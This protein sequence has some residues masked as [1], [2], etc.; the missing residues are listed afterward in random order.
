M[1][2]SKDSPTIWAW[3]PL[4][5]RKVTYGGAKFDDGK[6]REWWKRELGDGCL[7]RMESMGF[8]DV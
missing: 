1:E 3:T 8:L 5:S 7:T 2:Y 4:K 6:E